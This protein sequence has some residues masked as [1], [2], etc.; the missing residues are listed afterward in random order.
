MTE[1]GRAFT[2]LDIVETGDV[3]WALD[4][5]IDRIR[6]SMRHMQDETRGEVQPML[7]RMQAISVRLTRRYEPRVAAILNWKPTDAR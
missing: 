7:D 3:I 6:C 2:T 5:E 1:R 4:R